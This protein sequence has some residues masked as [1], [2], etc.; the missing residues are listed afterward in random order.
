M[1]QLWEMG[2]G[3][4][5]VP[6]YLQGATSLDAR[7]TVPGLVRGAWSARA[8]LVR[9]GQES[10]TRFVTVRFPIPP[11]PAVA[12]SAPISPQSIGLRQARELE[13]AEERLPPV[14]GGDEGDVDGHEEG[15]DDP[16]RDPGEVLEHS[17]DMPSKEGTRRGGWLLPPLPRGRYGSGSM[18]GRSGA[19][20]TARPRARA[21]SA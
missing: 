17:L 1:G 8:G 11:E 20:A 12:A 21:S 15:E 13:E 19:F 9:S 16:Q 18:R 7:E 6:V 4:A 14:G 10:R 5:G 3:S 2:A